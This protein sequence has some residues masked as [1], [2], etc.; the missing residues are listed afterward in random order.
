MLVF[1]SLCALALVIVFVRSRSERTTL[2]VDR[3]DPANAA[4]VASGRQL[5]TTRCASCHGGDLR[6]Q[7]GWPQPQANGVMPAA[8][9]DRSGRTWQRSDGWIFTTIRHGGQAT[10]PPGTISYMPAT[11]NLTDAEIWSII[12]YIKSSWPESL[13]E[14]QSQIR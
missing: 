12:S 10:A 11:G 1:L 3:A 5:Y 13:R 2:A 6:G 8:P 14:S 7:P 9:L 4:L